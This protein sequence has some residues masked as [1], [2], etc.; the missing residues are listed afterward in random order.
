MIEKFTALRR[1]PLKLDSMS[2]GL[3]SLVSIFNLEIGRTLVVFV[4][5]QYPKFYF[6]FYVAM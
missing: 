1:S 4:L 6:I 2:K 5:E 3:I